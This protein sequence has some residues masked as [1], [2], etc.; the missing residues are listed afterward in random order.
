MN[1][2]S[3]TGRW[4]INFCQTIQLI[5][6]TN[7]LPI[8][9]GFLI[10]SY[11]WVIVAI[12]DFPAVLPI[13]PAKLTIIFPKPEC[14]HFGPFISRRG[15]YNSAVE[16]AMTR[17]VHVHVGGVKDFLHG[18]PRDCHTNANNTVPIQVAPFQSEAMHMPISLGRP[19]GDCNDWI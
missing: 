7:M 12:P 9:N 10:T 8:S 3:G 15:V 17:P 11:M 5:Y 1:F 16:G 19:E 18:V 14:A 13:F 6:C 2:L 4:C